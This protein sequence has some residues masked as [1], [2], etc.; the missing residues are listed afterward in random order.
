VPE[1]DDGRDGRRDYR[2]V[3]VGKTRTAVR[4]KGCAPLTPGPSLT[5]GEGGSLCQRFDLTAPLQG[6]TLLPSWEKVAREARRMR[7]AELATITTVC[8]C[9]EAAHPSSD[10]ASP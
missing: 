1:G 4:R 5:R 10:P 6:A 8:A 2:Q 3:G 9:R 7:G